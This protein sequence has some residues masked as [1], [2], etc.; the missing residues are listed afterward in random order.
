MGLFC[1]LSILYCLDRPLREQARSHIGFVNDADQM[2]ERACS[3]RGRPGQHKFS[4]LLFKHHIDL[5]ARLQHFPGAFETGR[6][7]EAIAHTQGLGVA[8]AVAQH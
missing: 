7:H 1:C 6:N 2:W 8:I 3:R 5:A 4:G